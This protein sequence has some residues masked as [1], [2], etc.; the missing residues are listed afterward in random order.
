MSARNRPKL[1]R[2]RLTGTSANSKGSRTPHGHISPRRT[3]GESSMPI[4]L[5]PRGPLLSTYNRQ[6]G[7]W[8]RSKGTA[9][10]ILSQY[11]EV[12]PGTTLGHIFNVVDSEQD[13]KR[14]LGEYS[15]CD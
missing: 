7:N 2:D 8:V 9:F 1:G 15:G 6:S 11:V 3:V 4:R 10:S 14:F 13:L 12:E 5:T